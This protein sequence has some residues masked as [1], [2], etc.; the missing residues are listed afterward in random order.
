MLTK[1]WS[2]A[3]NGIDAISIFIEVNP[4]K[5]GEDK[6]Q[7]IG[8]P[9]TAVRES[10]SRVTS[11]IKHSGFN[12]PDGQTVIS[13]SPADIRK[14]GAAFDLPIALA[15]I[16]AAEGLPS[17]QLN[18]IL[19]VG[20]LRLD[21][22]VRPVKGILP[23]AIHARQK[24]ARALLVPAA[25]AS[26]AATINGIT[27]FGVTN[28]S[29]AVAIIKNP[30]S[31]LPT[32]N[33][34]IEE[35]YTVY[36]EI[37]DFS[38]VKGQAFAKR[39]LEI[40]AAGFHN[41]LLS[42]APGC[43]KSMLSKRMP[44]I[45]PPLSFEEALETTRIHSIGGLL[46]PDKPFVTTRP[47]RNPHHTIS[48]VGLLGGGAKIRPGEVTFAHNGVLFLDELPEFKRTALEVMRQPLENGDVTITRAN[49]TC[50][51]PARFMLIAAMNP[52]PCGYY[53]STRNECRCS[54]I[55]VQS[56]RNRISGPLLDRIDLHVHVQE[57]SDKELMNKRTGESSEQIYERV[58][59]AR[60]IQEQRFASSTISYNS[61]MNSQQMDKFCKLS[62]ES[63]TL[64][65][66]A[67]YNIKLS[68]RAYDRI[69]RIA[70]T[71][72]DLEQFQDIQP[73]HISEAI[74][75]RTLDRQNW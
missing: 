28:L 73:Q 19:S 35:L 64:L 65:K 33:I 48:D 37:E 8:L 70:R 23:T 75:Y 16:A 52:C 34:S 53:G 67:I 39:A 44:S 50:N 15:M 10:R 17:Q 3:I 25:N 22:T 57:L 43:G 58:K 60:Q 14:E 40:A 27:I 61:Q 66:T 41:V 38:D 45:L 46:S 12:Y 62:T 42:G 1:T 9:D 36:S 5:K 32:R 74:Q 2:A 59:K 68:A 56:Y 29:E 71:I 31:F 20:E 69:L 49:G 13:L 6:I 63:M 4:M 7:I 51:Y 47:F 72:A 26:E 24:G 30:A 11:A 55:Q 21:G 18:G 54:S